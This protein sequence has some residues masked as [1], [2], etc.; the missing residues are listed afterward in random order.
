MSMLSIVILVYAVVGIFFGFNWLK[1]MF[2]EAG[3]I[4]KI[5]A[6]IWIIALVIGI[7]KFFF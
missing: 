3:C 1:T 6:S 2:I 4:G 7:I 5:L